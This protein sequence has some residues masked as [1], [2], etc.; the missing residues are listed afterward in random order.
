MTLID[1]LL[2]FAPLVLVPIGLT[3]ADVPTAVARRTLHVARRW[4]P[5]GA[6]ATVLAFLLPAGAWAGTAALI[7]VSVCVVCTTVGLLLVV[8]TRSLRPTVLVA[9]ASFIYL[10]VGGSWMAISRFGLHPLQLPPQIV[11]LTGVHFHYAGFVT[12]TITSCL[13]R[14]IAGMPRASRIGAVAGLAIVV[15]SPLIAVGFVAVPVMLMIGAA[16]IVSGVIAVALLTLSA[17]VHGTPQSVAKAA[18]TASSLAVLI[19]M[20][21]ALSYATGRVFGLPALSIDSMAAIHGTLNAGGFALC[22]LVGWH[23]RI[24]QARATG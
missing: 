16:I 17:V 1:L 6:V 8:E 20:A 21:L 4:Q 5:A 14:A 2:L 7:W 22:G 11:E 9:A 18:L 12:L 15:G 24:D 19:P 13:M 3:L 23:G 10:L